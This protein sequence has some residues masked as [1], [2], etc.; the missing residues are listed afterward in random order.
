MSER[1]ITSVWIRRAIDWRRNAQLSFLD[2]DDR[3]DCRRKMREC[4]LHWKW[5]QSEAA[6]RTD[7]RAA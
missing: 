7:R 2:A 5:Q 1:P 6:T 3:K 4:A